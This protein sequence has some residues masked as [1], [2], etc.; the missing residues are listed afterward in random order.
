MLWGLEIRL[1]TFGSP[2]S[3]T[4]QQEE[5]RDGCEESP[6]EVTALAVCCS[7]NGWFFYGSLLCV[8]ESQ[9]ISVGKRETELKARRLCSS[10]SV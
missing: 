8:V 9:E 5:E 10:P 6:G 4:S 7:C 3:F 1:V 2:F